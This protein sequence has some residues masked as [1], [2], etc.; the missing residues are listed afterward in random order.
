MY[1]R[2][3]GRAH[4]HMIAE[5]AEQRRILAEFGR[6]TLKDRARQQ[7]LVHEHNARIVPNGEARVRYASKHVVGV[8]PH[9]VVD[10]STFFQPKR[11][12]T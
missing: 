1:D 2:A 10:I 8:V 12:H 9:E 6:V 3:V 7:I 5:K 4:D 11:I